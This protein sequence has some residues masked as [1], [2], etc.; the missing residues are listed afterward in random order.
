LNP[1]AR[2][3]IIDE[4][5]DCSTAHTIAALEEC[6]MKHFRTCIA[7]SLIVGCSSSKIPPTQTASGKV[8]YK[9]GD[10][11]SL[12]DGTVEFQL[13]S[14][15]TVIAAGQIQAD[16]TF[17]LQT[18]STDGAVTSSGVAAGEHKVRVVPP[19]PREEG[20]RHLIAP[21]YQNFETSG[22]RVTIPTDVIE[23]T[24]DRKR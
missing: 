6:I 5:D 4:L 1:R 8:L 3:R 13:V 16:G 19:N 9:G 12:Q 11:K 23:I 17:S 15:P 21:Q 20:S 22:I 18:W 14:D 10:V 24:V 2:W 7:L